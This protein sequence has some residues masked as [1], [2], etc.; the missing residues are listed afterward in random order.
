VFFTA[1]KCGNLLREIR[2]ALIHPHTNNM[3]EVTGDERG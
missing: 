1:V 3:L 2:K